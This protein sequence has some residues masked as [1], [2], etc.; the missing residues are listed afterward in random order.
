MLIWCCKYK[1]FL[2]FF[3][4]ICHSRFCCL[5][6]TAPRVPF[7]IRHSLTSSLSTL[8]EGIFANGSEQIQLLKAVD[9]LH[10]GVI[11]EIEKP[12]DA[13]AFVPSLRASMSKWKQMVLQL[14][15][16]VVMFLSNMLLYSLHNLQ[17]KKGIWI[18][19]PIEFANMVQYVVKVRFS[20]DFQ[21]CSCWQTL[22]KVLHKHGRPVISSFHY[23]NPG[24]LFTS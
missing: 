1:E 15:I 18:K 11:V 16:E 20:F 6:G 13:E 2:F 23:P 19:L 9:D 14:S 21:S 24:V 7:L 4:V 17:G 5:S 3:V 22:Q 12:M 10:G 8:E